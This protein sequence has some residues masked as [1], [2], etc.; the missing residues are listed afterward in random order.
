[1]C[2]PLLPTYNDYESLCT[3]RHD[4]KLNLVL[5]PNLPGFRAPLGGQQYHVSPH[6]AI[7][8]NKKKKT[9]CNGKN[10][11]LKQREKTGRGKGCL[12][13]AEAAIP[14]SGGQDRLKEATETKRNIASS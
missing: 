2:E 8:N 9:R 12:V 10:K 7:F 13:L 11:R 4:S 14:S 3:L 1:M 5:V 6:K